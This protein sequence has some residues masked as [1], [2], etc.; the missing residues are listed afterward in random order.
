MSHYTH[1]TTEERE[2]TIAFL[3]LGLSF[4]A[5]ARKLKR[6]PSTISR[7]IA[8]NSKKNGEY[9]S[10]FAEKKYK[11]RR[12]LCCRRCL[13]LNDELYDYVIERMFLNWTPEQIAGRAKLEKYHISFSYSTIYRAINTTLLP[14]WLRKKMR[15]RAKYKHKKPYAKRD[16]IPDT[17]NISK[18]PKSIERRKCFGHWESDTILGMRKTGAFATHVERKSGYLIALKLENIRDNIFNKATI[19]A[20]IDVPKHIKKTFTVDNGSEFFSHKQLAKETGMKV[21]FCDPYS[22]WQR[23]TNENTNGLLRQFFPKKTSFAS[24]T[25][26]LLDHVVYLINHRPRKR[27]GW[28]SPAEVLHLK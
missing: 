23:G 9:S 21:Y 25:Q 1:L 14:I 8:R 22:P 5:I 7:E 17:V 28:K 20:F 16:K 11:A 15:F 26:A 18:R 12:K 3:A 13:L 6:N 24:V 4:R 2:K 27:L 19:Q 10:S